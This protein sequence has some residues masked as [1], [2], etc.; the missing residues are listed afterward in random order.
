MQ[1]CEVFEITYTKVIVALKN[2]NDQSEFL[3]EIDLEL[4]YEEYVNG[5]AKGIYKN[6]PPV[7]KEDC[8]LKCLIHCRKDI[9]LIALCQNHNMAVDDKNGLLYYMGGASE[10]YFCS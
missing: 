2:V 4:Y 10:S 5:I 7:I 3:M 8:G 6:S 1:I 9:K